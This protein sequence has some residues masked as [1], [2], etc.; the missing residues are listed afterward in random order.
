MPADDRKTDATVVFERLR[1]EIVRGSVVPA[2]K[3][4]LAPLAERF[5]V[6]RGPLREA[7][8]KLAAEGLVVFED[9]RGFRVAPISRGDLVDVTET[10]RRIETLV[11]RDAIAHGDDAWEGQVLAALHR[12]GR[13]KVHDDDEA[14]R[15]AFSARHREFHA[16]LCAA[17][18]SAYLLGFRDTLYAHTE[19][20]RALAEARYRSLRDRRD[21]EG[22]HEAI[23]RAA[24]E[25]DAERACVLL[26]A[27]LSRTA[28]TLIEGYPELF[29]AHDPSAGRPVPPLDAR[30]GT[31]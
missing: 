8:S 5:G 25:R 19:R 26:E 1:D 30:A 10:R 21:V 12:L 31:A 15:S 27:H 7:A 22:E 2:Q 23:A 17:C 24:I 20:Y 3:L 16:A 13:V 14:S 18:P 11:L 9:H 4:K 6:G 28:Q 29:G